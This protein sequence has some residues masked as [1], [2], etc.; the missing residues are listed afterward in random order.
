MK[1]RSII[2]IAVLVIAVIVAAVLIFAKPA[3]QPETADETGKQTD[4]E[5]KSTEPMPEPTTQ[6][7]IIDEDKKIT[8]KLGV[9]TV[10]D[11]PKDDKPSQEPT[12]TSTPEV[13]PP[14]TEIIIPD[15]PQMLSYEDFYALAPDKK[16]EFLHSFENYDLFY[17]W[18]VDAQAKF[19]KEH[20]DIEIGPN[21]S[22]D[23]SQLQR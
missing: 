3:A 11:E 19:T 15:D 6:T 17:E 22:I 8:A 2:I 10:S 18:L 21:G 5:A 12:S 16:D 20:P 4:V 14:P 7:V 23:L 1:K 9:E 13:T